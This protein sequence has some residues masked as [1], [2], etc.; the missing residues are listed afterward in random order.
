[1]TESPPIYLDCHATTP[2]DRRVAELMLHY[3][4]VVENALGQYVLYY[5]IMQDI[6]PE[7]SLYLA[8]KKD[9]FEDIFEEPIGE[10][11]LRNKRLSLIVFDE[12]KEA[13]CQW[14]S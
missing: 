11:L 13:I 7:R 10:V 5:D 4:T 3:M 12:K 9:V 2:S 1:M 14:I 6:E 8:I